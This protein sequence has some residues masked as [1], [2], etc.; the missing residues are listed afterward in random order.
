MSS[1]GVGSLSFIHD[2]MNQQSYV[3]IL[4]DNLEYSAHLFGLGNNFLFMQ[5]NDPKHTSNY[6]SDW[7]EEN[8]FKLL[9]TPPQSLDIN[10]IEHLWYHLKRKLGDKRYRN[11]EQ[12]KNAILAEWNQIDPEYT[13]KLVESMPKRLEAVV[14]ANGGHTKY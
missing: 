3:E 11:K 9:K 13:R 14:K 10:P 4:N 7:L 2:K 1:A 12:L 6:A 8:G 5:D